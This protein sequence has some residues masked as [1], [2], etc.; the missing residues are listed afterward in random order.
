MLGKANITLRQIAI[1]GKQSSRKKGLKMHSYSQFD[2]NPE[3]T[4]IVLSLENLPGESER[5]VVLAHSANVAFDV[6]PFIILAYRRMGNAS[7]ALFLSFKGSL[8][9]REKLFID[10]MGI[11]AV[12][13]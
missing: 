4:H 9:H 5:K 11:L 2:W 10:V 7:A 8:N 12:K 6:R 1:E 3:V 13:H